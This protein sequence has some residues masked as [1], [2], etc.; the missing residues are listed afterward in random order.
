MHT[1]STANS[2]KTHHRKSCQSS[3]NRRAHMHSITQFTHTFISNTE[4]LFIHRIVDTHMQERRIK[5]DSYHQ[6]HD[7]T[8]Y[9]RPKQCAC[10]RIHVYLCT[11]HRSEAD[12]KSSRRN[13]TD[14]QCIAF[15]KC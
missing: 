12:S 4:K 1:S 14:P 2:I 6:S 7:V 15:D 13:H 9:S 8:H 11:H 10:M 5:Q 3:I